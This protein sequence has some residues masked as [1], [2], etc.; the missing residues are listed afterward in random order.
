[1]L[2]RFDFLTQETLIAAILALIRQFGYKN[3]EIPA[4]HLQLGCQAAEACRL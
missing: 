2:I 4:L 1:M 3:F